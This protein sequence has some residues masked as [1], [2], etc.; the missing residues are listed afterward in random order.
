MLK[1][2]ISSKLFRKKSSRINLSKADE[3]IKAL[4]I[5][6]TSLSFQLQSIFGFNLLQLL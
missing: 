2:I 4:S 6:M 5:I 3:Y 1:L